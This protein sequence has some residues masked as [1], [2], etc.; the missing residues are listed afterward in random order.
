MTAAGNQKPELLF[1]CQTLPYP[2]DGGVEIRTF[3][4]IR[5]LSQAF[6]ITALCFYRQAT[7][8]GP[9]EVQH[10]V[11]GLSRYC[12][13]EA[14]PIPQEHHRLRFMWDHI[15][16]V[17]DR[18]AYTRFVYDSR[19][20]RGRLRKLLSERNYTLV[21]VDSLDLCAYLPYVSHLPVACT[22]HN[23]ESE[24]LRR[25]SSVERSWLTRWYFGWQGDLT[26]AIERRWLPKVDLNVVVSGDD[27]RRFSGMVSDARLM[28][29]PNG[30]D[31]VAIRPSVR[32]GRGLVFVGAYGWYP[33]RDAMEY[34]GDVIL[35]LVRKSIPEVNVTWV[36]RI[37]AGI[38]AQYERR[39]G[40]SVAGY[41]DDIRPLV[42]SA[43]CYVVPLR[44]GGG[45]R[46]KILD[47]WAM[48]KAVVST[49]VGCE[50]L[51]AID[52]R[53]ILV[54]DAPDEF[55]AAVVSVIEDGLLRKTLGLEARRTVMRQYDWDVIGR[56]LM[57]EYERL[58]Q[59]V[60]REQ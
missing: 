19:A 7:R 52:G 28:V 22:H 3:N 25:R 11:A 5:I 45:S 34:F 41:V 1:L 29:V 31:T 47:A 44:V 51:D 23:V 32:D 40:I 33:N 42:Q 16:S 50:G 55:A 2:P 12:A 58:L 53:N 27:A 39:Y 46:L 60:A 24:L 26:E 21:H 38:G 20:F 36:G 56:D 8:G 57:Q 59:P 54:R 18:V 10:S 13:V 37:P 4:I 15:R 14:F 49:S 9:P 35:P 30:V 6:D 17:S 48:G 43:A